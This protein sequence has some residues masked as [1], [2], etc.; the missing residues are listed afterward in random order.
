M[1]KI[2]TIT[3]L[4][5]AGA[6]LANA[7]SLVLPD[8]GLLTHGDYFYGSQGINKVFEKIQK[9]NYGAYAGNNGGSGGTWSDTEGTEGY[10][11]NCGDGSGYITLAGRNGTQGESFGLVLG[12]EIVAGTTFNTLSLSIEVAANTNLNGLSM[13]FGIGLGS[14]TT[15][16]DTETT[17]KTLSSSEATIFDVVLSFDELQTWSTGNKI[18]VAVAGPAFT[19][20]ENTYTVKIKDVSYSTVPE[21][22]AFGLLAGLG[23]LALAGTRRRRRKA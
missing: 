16:I 7:E 2:I 13:G 19:P 17:T 5:A 12:S 22:S 21:P 4:L 18:M 6:A 8:S 23:A 9:E 11:T 14:A 1:K 15:T 3:T 20:A 10:W